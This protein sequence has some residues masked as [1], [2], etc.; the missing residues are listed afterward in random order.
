MTTKMI[1]E[2]EEEEE[3]E[4]EEDARYQMKTHECPELLSSRPLCRLD[5]RA[6]RV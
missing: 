4:E 2:E 6:F 5:E 1:L 3:K